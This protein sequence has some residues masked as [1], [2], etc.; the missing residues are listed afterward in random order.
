MEIF[1]KLIKGINWSV[2]IGFVSSGLFL[3]LSFTLSYLIAETSSLRQGFIPFLV[4]YAT[5]VGYFCTLFG[6]VL[7]FVGIIHKALGHLE[8]QVKNLYMVNFL[9]SLI[10]IIIL[11]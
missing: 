2:F 7:I 10:P 4:G 8:T 5:F 1:N 3:A 9:F 6:V 11:I